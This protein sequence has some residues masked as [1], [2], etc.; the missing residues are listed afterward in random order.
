MVDADTEYK[1]LS[2]RARRKCLLGVTITLVE[3][4]LSAS[5][6]LRLMAVASGSRLRRADRL[7]SAERHLSLYRPNVVIIDLGLPDGSGL[8]LIETLGAM[9]AP[10]PGIIAFSGADLAEWETKARSAGADAILPKPVGSLAIFQNTV[11]SVLPDRDQRPTPVAAI[12]SAADT[13]PPQV[14]RDDLAHALDL[15][16]TARDDLRLDSLVYACQ[17]IASLAVMIEDAELQLEAARILAIGEASPATE[18]AIERLR[19]ILTDRLAREDQRL[20]RT[21]AG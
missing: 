11:L 8:D 14:R 17:F 9:P 6:A 16:D 4:S 18:G 7:L 2:T 19:H 3:D 13:L 20:Q 12:G 15:I 21:R 10:R 1:G 5:E